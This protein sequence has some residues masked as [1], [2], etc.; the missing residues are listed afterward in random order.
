ME[1]VLAAATPFEIQPVLEALEKQAGTV[2]EHR[3]SPLIT[4]VGSVAATW[5]LMRHLRSGGPDLIIQA[6]I[7]GTLRDKPPGTVF[8]V[9]EETM[10]DTGVWEEGRFRDVFDLKL[11]GPNTLPFSGGRLVNPW[12]RLLEL[13]GLE[14]VGGLT[15]NEITTHP[16]RI[17]WYQQNTTA[18]VESMEGGALH[19]VCLQ[20][21]MPFL[22]LR[23]VSNAV[24]VRDKM[25][26]DIRGAISRL[27]EV[28][29]ELLKNPKLEEQ[30]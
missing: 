17:K 10:A 21:N 26:W 8:V 5:A 24:G 11:A 23:A 4:G 14:A 29:I 27:N 9:G 6:G 7:A 30:R 3:I 20:E 25:K 12:R 18:V 13:T 16:E 1:I 15:V 19:Y 28:L 2:T 22:Q